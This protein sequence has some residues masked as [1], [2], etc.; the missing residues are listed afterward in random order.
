L[1]RDRWKKTVER[2]KAY[3]RAVGPREEEEEE[4]E[5]AWLTVWPCGMNSK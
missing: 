3:L 4:E 2:T 1:E 5:K